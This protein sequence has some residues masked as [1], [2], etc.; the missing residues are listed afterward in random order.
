LASA[1]GQMTLFSG[2]RS[3]QST[4]ATKCL[5]AT[6]THFNWSASH[7]PRLSVS[8]GEAIEVETSLGGGARYLQSA[9]PEDV[10]EVT[11]TS[12]GLFLTGPIFVEGAEPGDAIGIELLEI[13][14]DDWG[15]TVVAPG[16]GLLEDEFPEPAVRIW[17]LTARH[18]AKF[19][20]EITIALRPFLGA[21]G[22][23]PP[24]GVVLPSIPPSR[25]GGNLD[26]RRFTSGST[27]YLPVATEGALLSVGDAHAA[28]G[29]G[30][31]C[32]SAI[33][34]SARVVLRLTVHKHRS[35]QSPVLHFRG[36]GTAGFRAG[37]HIATGIGPDLYVAA[38]EATRNLIEWLSARC[39]LSRV[40]AY[41]LCSVCADLSISEVVDRPNWVVSASLPL[42][43]FGKSAPPGP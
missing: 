12:P 42:S 16:F 3:P 32:G 5:D 30:E 6:Q 34:T 26:T 22:V 11:A 24:L 28:Q 27:L 13:A 18:S 8:P 2:F 36:S 4:P 35:L 29:D 20:D 38:Q 14:I 39:G 9:T 7:P 17:D 33:E 43:I 21:V 31:V 19:N 41:M 25:W 23:A 1:M 10:R 15:Y 37:A 40:D